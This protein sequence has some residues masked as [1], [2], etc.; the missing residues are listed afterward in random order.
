MTRVVLVHGFTQTAASWDT[1]RAALGPT[2]MKLVAVDLPGHGAHAAV[3][4]TFVETAA[5]LASQGGRAVYVGYSLGA[6][7]CLRVA[8]DRP[9]LVAGLVTIGATAGLADPHEREARRGADEL[10]ARDLERDGVDAFLARWLA[11]PLFRTLAPEAAGLDERRCN[12]VEGLAHAL[13]HLGTGSMEPLW[14]RLSAF[15][16]RTL[17]AAGALDTKFVDLAHRMATGLGGPTEVVRIADAGHAAH[18]ERPHDVARLL[19]RFV[20]RLGSDQPSR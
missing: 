8:L 12:T 16:G 4:S 10:L 6:R 1:V 9:D 13:R 14:D 17:L 19:S 15:T 7:L 18:L 20:D 2:A 3:R 5:W 11:Q